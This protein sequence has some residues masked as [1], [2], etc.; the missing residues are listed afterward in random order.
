MIISNREST[1]NLTLYPVVKPRQ[2]K[3]LWV[4]DLYGNEEC[5]QPALSIEQ[6]MRLK[7]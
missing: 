6:S 2:E 4:E 1:Q 3:A 7:Y 5:M